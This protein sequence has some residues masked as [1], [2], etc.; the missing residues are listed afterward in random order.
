[1]GLEVWLGSRGV[2]PRLTTAEPV[3]GPQLQSGL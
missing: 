2:L 1:M 3:R